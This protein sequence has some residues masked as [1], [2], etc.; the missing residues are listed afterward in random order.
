MEKQP[1]QRSE[2]EVK[3]FS[4]EQKLREFIASRLTLQEMLKEVPHT[5]G[6]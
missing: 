3:P 4:G 1:T 2:G 6:K 5:E